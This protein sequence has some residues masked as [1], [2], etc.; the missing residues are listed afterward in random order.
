MCPSV[1]CSA[2]MH[3]QPPL[4]T[5]PSTVSGAGSKVGWQLG[6][7][8]GRLVGQE[9]EH[10]P[11]M[12]PDSSVSKWTVCITY[13]YFVTLSLC[14]CRG[15][16]VGGGALVL[17]LLPHPASLVP[18]PMAQAVW[19]QRCYKCTARR[20]CSSSVCAWRCCLQSLSLC[21]L[22]Y[23]LCVGTKGG[24]GAEGHR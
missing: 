13:V 7:G 4:D 21:Q 18:C 12:T 6:W 5:L 20:T 9:P 11:S 2:C 23:S 22:C 17:V 10:F 16:V 19:R 15:V 3:L 14:V 24:H 8:L 1:P